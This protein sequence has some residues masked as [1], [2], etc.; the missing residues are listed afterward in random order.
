[1]NYDTGTGS[2]SVACDA[3]LTHVVSASYPTDT[4]HSEA[5]DIS[6]LVCKSFS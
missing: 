4:G 3:V 1:M 2:A 5:L 6:E